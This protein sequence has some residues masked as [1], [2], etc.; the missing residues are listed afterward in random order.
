[1]FSTA[2]GGQCTPLFASVAYPTD[3]SSGETE[4][5]PRVIEQSSGASGSGDVIPMSCAAC[6]MFGGPTSRASCANTTLIE[7]CVAVH[8]STRPPEAGSALWTVQPLHSGSVIGSFVLYTLPGG[9]PARKAA[10]SVNGLNADP[11]CRPAVPPSPVTR[12]WWVLLKFLPETSTRRAP[13]CVST[14][15]TAACGSE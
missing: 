10:T 9:M 8:R 11:A 4:P 15:D 12:S 14:I 3:I 5:V 6:A 2:Y 1:M 7:S 13:V